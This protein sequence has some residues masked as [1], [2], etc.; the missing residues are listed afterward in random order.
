VAA[1]GKLLRSPAA[2]QA[3]T[4]MHAPGTACW[5]HAFSNSVAGS[6]RQSAA[7]RFRKAAAPAAC[8]AATAVAEHGS[9]SGTAASAV[10]SRLM[11]DIVFV[12]LYKIRYA[13]MDSARAVVEL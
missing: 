11:A 5:A 9:F 6:P 13:D 3:S 8:R 12:C 4:G 10:F 2:N 7:V 1:G